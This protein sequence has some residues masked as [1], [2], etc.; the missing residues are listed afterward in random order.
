M[1]K[2][3]NNKKK[4]RRSTR[5]LKRQFVE[6][7]FKKTGN[8]SELCRE[9][10]VS[11]QTYYDWMEKDEKFKKNIEI[12]QEG[13]LDFA[14]SKLLNLIDEKNVAA[15]IFFLKTKGKG[16]GYVERIEQLLQGDEFKPLRVIVSKDGNKPDI[17]P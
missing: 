9:T 10:G 3:D 4:E 12:Q 15:V 1:T 2:P 5:F 8:I 11:R 6:N 17:T 16:R 13:I 7:F 14:E